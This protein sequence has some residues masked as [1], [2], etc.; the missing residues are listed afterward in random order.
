MKIATIS[1]KKVVFVPS[2]YGRNRLRPYLKPFIR[3]SAERWLCR[4]NNGSKP[5]VPKAHELTEFRIAHA[6]FPK[7][8]PDN[9]Q[10]FCKEINVTSVTASS[11]VLTGH[12]GF[13]WAAAF[14]PDSRHL[15]TGSSDFTARLWDITTGQ[16]VQTFDGQGSVAL[17]VAFAPGGQH[18]VTGH[19]DGTTRLWDVASGAEV[20]RFLGHTRQVYSAAFSPDGRIL[21]T[22][23]KD[24]TVRLWDVATQQ[25]IH[26]LEGHKS[27][28]VA[29]QFSADGRQLL[30]V[31]WDSIR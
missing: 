17:A 22:G 4:P 12:T 30:S 29:G 13:V 19:W 2:S 18:V 27:L 6:I 5:I 10:A 14:S 24:R 15:L 31:S 28:V 9:I 1:G 20:G 8:H 3:N 21:M 26:T 7:D 11:I 23:S 25:P 16:A